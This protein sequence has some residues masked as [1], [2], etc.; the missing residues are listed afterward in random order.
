MKSKVIL[1]NYSFITGLEKSVFRTIVIAGPLLIE[2]LPS[3]WMNITLGGLL[4]LAINYAKNKDKK[5]VEV[6]TSQS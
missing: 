4:T 3:T 1:T 2:L 5:E 6:T